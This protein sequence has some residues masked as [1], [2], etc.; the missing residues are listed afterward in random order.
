MNS[1]CRNARRD[2]ISSIELSSL[3]GSSPEYSG[4][5]PTILANYK[6]GTVNV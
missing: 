2:L 3:A 1:S 6:K 5:C 4:S